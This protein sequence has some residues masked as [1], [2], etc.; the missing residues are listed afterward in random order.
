MVRPT[1][2]AKLAADAAARVQRAHDAGEQL[3]FLADEAPAK[4]GPRDPNAPKRGK[5]KA[6][7]QMRE[8]LAARGYRLPEQVMAELAGLNS[9][10][11]VLAGAMRET[12]E[13]LLWAQDGAAKERA[14][15]GGEREAKPTMAQR[16][17]TLQQVLAVRLRAADALL[18]YGLAKVSG[19]VNVQQATTIVM[20]GAAAPG[21]RPGET[22]RDIT[23]GSA[24]RMVPPP[25]P[26]E[27]Q[28]KQQVSGS[29]SVGSDT[30]SRTE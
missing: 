21:P 15:G 13:I 14:P 25:L 29:K 4:S 28:Q 9:G 16:L 27:I 7:S 2:Y 24:R 11:S 10:E 6:L 19:D 18:P 1:K 30:E 20:P 3:T 26:D 5:G 22:A 12:E 17:A 23:P 8:F